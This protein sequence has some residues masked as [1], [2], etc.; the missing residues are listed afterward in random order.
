AEKE[1]SG[2]IVPMVVSTSYH[3]PMADV[4]GGATLAAPLSMIFT[5]FVGGWLWIGS[6]NMW[7]FLGLFALLFIIFH[8]TVKR[9]VRLKRLF[10]SKKQIE[11][12]VQEA[13]T[14]SFFK[15]G[16]Y[17]TREETGVLIF[18]S[19]FEHRV[20]VL[21]DR[22]INEK[23]PEGQWDEVVGIIVD[24]IKQK[25]QAEAICEAVEKVGA[26]LKEHFPV[27]PDDEDELKSL[28]VEE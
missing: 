28:I 6:Q 2:E 23:V 9:T 8:E 14:T 4:V 22:G 12:E 21:A 1:T 27:R 26:V 24:G 15:E 18:V 11:E 25:R 3:Y 7:V 5:P 10:L 20:W 19:V 17:R 13:A 16:L